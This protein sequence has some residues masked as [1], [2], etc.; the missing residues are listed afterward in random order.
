MLDVRNLQRLTLGPVDLSIGARE[1]V[2]LQGASGSGKTMLMRALA[3]LD[4]AQGQVT[5]DG[6]DREAMTG[7]DW[8]RAV[9][10]VPAEAGWW[11]ET[12]REHFSDWAATASLIEELDLPSDCGDWAV[13]RASTGERQR[14][15]LIRAIVLQ[16]RVLLLDEPT[17]GLDGYSVAR[18]EALIARLADN[19][20]AV[21]WTTHDNDQARR[22][23]SRTLFLKDGKPGEA[24]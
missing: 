23:A 18:V 5:L 12:I 22:V 7:P 21:L 13:S 20:T 3:D 19:G 10:W 14:L 4:P 6:V 17:S 16:P 15:A 24:A 2:A 11:A 8:R 1:V 9:A